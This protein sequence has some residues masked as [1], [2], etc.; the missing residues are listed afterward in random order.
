MNEIGRSRIYG[1]IHFEFDNREGKA[2]GARIGDYASAN[3][4]LPNARLPEVRI[5]LITNHIPELIV[6]AHVGATFVLE[7][8]S[9]LNQWQQ[10]STNLAVSGGVALRDLSASGSNMRFYRAVEQP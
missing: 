3:F 1:G 10:I 4:L 7:A 6:H 8:T 2:S 9:D 5:K